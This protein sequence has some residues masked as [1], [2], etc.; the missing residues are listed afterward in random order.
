[1]K[2][3]ILVSRESARLLEA[4]L[5]AAMTPAPDDGGVGNTEPLTVDFRGVEGIAPSFLDELVTLFESLLAEAGGGE[6]QLILSHPPTRLSSK[7][8]AMARGHAMSVQL[9]PDGSW[10]LAKSRAA[11]A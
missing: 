5:R 11:G 3:R 4:P 8:E 7:F 9:Q 6:R 2:D 1:M 10:L